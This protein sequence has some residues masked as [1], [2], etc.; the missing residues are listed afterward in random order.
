MD[1][2]INA[3]DSR[4]ERWKALLN[5][6]RGGLGT[7]ERGQI[8]GLCRDLQ[9]LRD[10]CVRTTKPGLRRALIADANRLM[11]RMQRLLTSLGIELPDLTLH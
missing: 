2:A 3:I 10:W 11:Q 8:V 5:D 1:L 9:A 4:V 6:P 7:S